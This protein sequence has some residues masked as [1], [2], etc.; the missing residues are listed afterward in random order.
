MQKKTPEGRF[1]KEYN[2]VCGRILKS[3]RTKRNLSKRDLARGLLSATALDNL[4]SGNA[5]WTKLT[6]DM[7]M[8]RMGISPEGFETAASSGELDRWRMR[9]D[10]CLLAGED[11]ARAGEKLR[12]YRDRYRRREPAEEQFLLKAEAIL[13][14]PARDR[15]GDVLLKLAEAAIACT[16]PDAGAE[17]IQGRLLAPAELEAYLLK[18]AALALCGR[19]ENAWDLWQEVWDYPGQHSWESMASVRILPQAAVLGIELA[20]R[21][22]SP[23]AAYGAGREALEQLHCCR[24]HCYALPLLERFCRLPARTPEEEACIAQAVRFR[25]AFR[26]VYDRFHYPGGRLWQ[27]ICV[28][29]TREAGL[30][31]KMLRTF[32]G[33][34][35]EAAVYDENEKVQI[36]TPRQLEKIENGTHKPSYENYNRLLKRYL[37]YGSWQTAMLETDSAEVLAMRQE[38]STLISKR[39]WDEA[40]REMGRLRRKVNPEYPKVK[41]EFLFWDALLLKEEGSLEKSL[42]MLTDALHIT[43]PDLKNADMKY[44]V[45][46]RE[47]AIIASNI[48]A[49][50]RLMGRFEESE[51]WF[52]TVSHSLELQR[53]RTGIPQTGYE[54]LMECYDNLLGDTGRFEEAVAASEEAIHNYLKHFQIPCLGSAFYRVA[55]NTMEIEIRSEEPDADLRQK[56][57]SSFQISQVLADLSYNVDEME[58]LKARE[59]KYL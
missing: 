37:A 23:A 11:P 24:C 45:F 19:E 21:R 28:E 18:S 8:L 48:A 31:L 22:G 44:W 9:E 20:L 3:E 42:A 52:E 41:Q 1:A 5:R 7:L 49:V 50:Y 57:K 53:R 2:L 30:I 6:G 33:L 15:E 13:A 26:L 16:V 14:F 54:I 51:T 29:N 10:I 17:G 34:S 32:K 39:E 43:V 35:R 40:E 27:G 36:V 46:Q 38:I 12:G 4:E 55:W 59:Q 56:R 47:E 25:D 58:F